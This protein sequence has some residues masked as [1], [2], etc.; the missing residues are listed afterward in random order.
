[1]RL[2][3]FASGTVMTVFAIAVP[4]M[5]SAAKLFVN[6]YTSASGPF[7]GLV[8]VAISSPWV[9]SRVG[10]PLL[11]CSLLLTLTSPKAYATCI[12][13]V[14]STA[15]YSG[16][17]MRRSTAHNSYDVND[18][19]TFIR[20]MLPSN[21]PSIDTTPPYSIHWCSGVIMYGIRV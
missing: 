3:A 1:M 4:Y 12:C 11:L 9:N 14:Y 16:H 7:A 20:K 21:E 10:F 18:A 15:V 8:I 19:T 13:E 2:L 5:G 6:L 17:R